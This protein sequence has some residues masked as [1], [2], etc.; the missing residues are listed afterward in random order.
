MGTRN[1][2]PASH[3]LSNMR[4]S[5]V[6]AL[7]LLFSLAAHGADVEHR[8]ASA[9]PRGAVQRVVIDVPHGH[10]TIRNDASGRIAVAGVASRDYDSQREMKWAQKVV[11]D[12]SIEIYVSGSEAV[13]KRK[14]GPNADSW[15]SRKFTGFDLRIDLPPGVD[16]QF[17]TS[18]G[19]IDLDGDFGHVDLTLRAG[20]I[21]LKMPRARV[22]ALDASTRIG[23][24][25]TNLGREIVTKEGLFPGRIHFF[26]PAGTSNVKVHTTVGEVR[27]VLK[28]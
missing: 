19:E 1:F 26:N 18:A 10:F 28:P 3:V 4:R 14:F 16:I 15:R 8:F 5:L 25:R 11:N 24:V 23:E 27:V 13:I 21:D 20:E 9:V 6:L 7:A 2:P 22:R 12:T 17:E